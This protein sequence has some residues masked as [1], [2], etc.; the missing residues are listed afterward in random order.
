MRLS[1]WGDRLG[2]GNAHHRI[3]GG[4]EMRVISNQEDMKWQ[5]SSREILKGGYEM[6]WPII[7]KE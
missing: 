6:K 2:Y 4:R 7:S 5:L 3:E 1:F